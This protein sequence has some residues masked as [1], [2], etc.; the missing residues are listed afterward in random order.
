MVTPRRR[1][2][3]VRSFKGLRVHSWVNVAKGSKIQPG[4]QQPRPPNATP[5]ASPPLGATPML[6]KSMLL[7]SGRQL[8]VAMR[9]TR[10]RHAVM[11]PF[12]QEGPPALLWHQVCGLLSHRASCM[13]GVGWQV[14]PKLEANCKEM[15]TSGHALHLTCFVG[16]Q[17]PTRRVRR[18]AGRRMQL[19]NSPGSTIKADLAGAAMPSAFCRPKSRLEQPVGL[20]LHLQ[21]QSSACFTPSSS[22]FSSPFWCSSCRMSLQQREARGNSRAPV[23]EQSCDAL[24]L[25]R[26]SSWVAG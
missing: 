2:E 11:Q 18:G 13:A 21:S 12:R 8:V 4:A 25:G 6:F 17:K 20:A 14:A 7:A 26:L 23:R 24:Q 22:C 15:S 3:R 19:A 10:R 9:N 5:R 16:C 1:R